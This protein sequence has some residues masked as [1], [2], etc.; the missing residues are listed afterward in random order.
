MESKGWDNTEKKESG[1]LKSKGWGG[2]DT[3]NWIPTRETVD[4]AV[5]SCREE[6]AEQNKYIKDNEL[7]DKLSS[8]IKET[9]NKP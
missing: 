8:Q 6:E 2:F 4:S 9:G 7:F 1:C 5:Q 3:E